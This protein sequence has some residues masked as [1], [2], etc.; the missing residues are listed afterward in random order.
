MI[1]YV[2][3]YY[4]WLGNQMF[5]YAATYSLARHLGVPCRFPRNTP[6]LFSIFKLSALPKAPMDEGI[7]F[8]ERAFEFNEGFW[9]LPDGTELSGYFQSERYFKPFADE[10]RREFQP[11]VPLPW[12]V[13]KG[14]VSIHVRRGDY[15]T[16]PEHHPPCTVEYY[17]EAM[18]R[19]P[20]EHFI[21]FSD[22]MPWCKENLR[23]PRIEYS[24]GF[25]PF[26]DLHRM[27][28]C[29]HHIIANSS[30]SWWGAWL[31][32]NPGKRVIAPKRWFGPKKAGW[33][34][35]DLLPQGWEAI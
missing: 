19:F 32:K 25:Y 27:S 3:G 7:P 14:W 20:N 2:S 26:A 17:R 24:E 33:N 28:L 16:F 29:D 34:T 31:G 35:K 21:V 4:G 15:L 5:Q 6:D 8:L 10:V 22:D 18:S 9:A 13:F 12:T 23:G 1:S 11:L 30:F